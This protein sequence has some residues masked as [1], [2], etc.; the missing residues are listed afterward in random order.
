MK[1]KTFLSTIQ[2]ATAQAVSTTALL[3][4][5]KGGISQALWR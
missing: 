1:I 3:Q 2:S 4:Q 5:V